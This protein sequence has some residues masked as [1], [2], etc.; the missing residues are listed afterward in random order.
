MIP[1]DVTLFTDSKSPF[2]FVYWTAASG[3]RVKRSTK[4]PHAGGMYCGEHLTKA[5]A[6]KR[7]YAVGYKMAQTIS[8]APEGQSNIT[9]RDLF[10]TMLS[11]KL[12]HVS[13]RTYYNART[14]YNQFCEWLGKR[15][16]EPARLITKAII[17]EW[18]MYRRTLVRRATVH[19][20]LSVISAA[21]NYAVDSEFMPSNPCRGVRIAPDLRD[22]KVVKEAFSVE[23]VRLLI[24]KLPDEW[25]SA[26]RCCIGTYGQRL[27]DILELKWE[28]F[29]FTAR[30]V[31]IT[32]GK[33]ARPLQQPMQEDFY[34]WAYARH[35][36]AQQ[37]GGDAAI[38]VHP[39]LRQKPN[40][41]SEFTQLVRLHGI[42]LRGENAGGNRRT[43]HSKTFH[44][45]RASVVT[46]LHA[47]GVS[48]GL[49]MYLVGHESQ[50]VHSVYLRPSEDQL[51]VA[52][53]NLPK[54]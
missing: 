37:A 31:R 21:F 32:T 8:S 2:W 20:A 47:A 10:D 35:E 5:Q 29:D 1:T 7:A 15:A 44:S 28:Q 18:V 43:W 27:G 24:D 30:V 33:T 50:D 52:A 34:Q 12:G 51:A 13:V 41:S 23:E 9:V 22:E 25:S 48:Q 16:H 42:G 39:V 53:A 36:A 4:V 11:G 3:R 38:Y 19:K 17:N 14:D 6:K 45:L 54:L 26:V 46:M 49:A 40:P